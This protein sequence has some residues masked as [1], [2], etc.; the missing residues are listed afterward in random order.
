MYAVVHNSIAIR[1]AIY[2]YQEAPLL[3]IGA[4]DDYSA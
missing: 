3:G 2:D 1:R 4:A